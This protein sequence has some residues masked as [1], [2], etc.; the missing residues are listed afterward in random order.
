MSSGQFI[1]GPEVT[2]FEEDFA[3]YCESTTRSASGAASMH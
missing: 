3:A 1:L 2:A